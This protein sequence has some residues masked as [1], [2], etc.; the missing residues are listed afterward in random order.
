MTTIP[1]PASATIGDGCFTFTDTTPLT[2]DPALDRAAGWLRQALAPATGLQLPEGPGGVEIRLVE[3]LDPEAYR[4]SATT[5]S[6]VIEATGQ[7]GAFY[8]AQTLRQLLDPAAFR[9]GRTADRTWSIPEITVSDA[10]A[11]GWRGCLIDVARHF[12]PKNDLLRYIDL[13][14]AHKLN[15]LHLHLTDDQGWRL[16]IR[17]YPKLTKVGSWRR[18]SPLGARRHRMYD[19]RPHGG[20]YTQDDIRE[21]VSYAADRFVTVVPE[22]DLPGHTQAAIA[23]YP[24]LGNLGTPLD[25]RT[26]WGVGEN[27]LNVADET[28]AFF[29][30]V[31][32]EVIELFPGEYICVGGDE[33]PK[34][35]WNASV[36]AKERM[37]E[38][39]LRDADE[40]QTWLM[41]HFT[42]YLLARGR[43]PVGWDELLEGGLP[44][45][46][47]VGAWRGP[48]CAAMAARAGHDVVVSPFAETYLDF[49]Q[50]EGEQ[51]PVPIGSVTSLRSIYAFDPV[52]PGL[53]ERDRI[54]GAQAALWTEHIDSPRLLDYM[55][56][57]RLA[58]FAEAMWSEER[59]F[60]D[61]LVRLAVHEKRL[62]AL[63]VEY[64]PAGGPHPWQ[65]R[66]DAPGHPRTRAEIDAQ[67]ATWTS[68][69]HP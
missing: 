60:D 2:A 9:A 66:P 53:A 58:A 41:R 56:F 38:L 24:E 14:A 51:E 67:L 22:I 20:Y 37:R 6:V 12:L 44:P 1:A 68:N 42:D 55:A 69:L 15:V 65:Q 31:L 32:D 50:A 43:K 62:D 21:I 25:V 8:G 57:P 36:P 5:R 18:E 4:L 13:L 19:G 64:R 49:R 3:G 33:T 23:A 17:K 30:D 45:G 63:G 7:A 10:P 34:T 52:P 29:T 11:Y 59:D 39:G 47:T 54:L 27:V 26:D 46:V 35:Q 61:F 16:E 28:I 40:L 48:T